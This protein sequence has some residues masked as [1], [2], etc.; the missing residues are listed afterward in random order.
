MRSEFQSLQGGGKGREPPNHTV[1]VTQCQVISF[2][3]CLEAAD[4]REE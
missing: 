4:I 1:R 2:L 3:K